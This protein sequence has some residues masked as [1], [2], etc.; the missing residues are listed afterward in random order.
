MH[1]WPPKADFDGSVTNGIQAQLVE[2]ENWLVI[3]APNPEPQNMRRYEVTDY[4]S[5]VAAR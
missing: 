2:T 4:E 1:V 3:S 5:A